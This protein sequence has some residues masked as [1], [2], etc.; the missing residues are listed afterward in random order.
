[1]FYETVKRYITKY[2]TVHDTLI[3]S[4]VL[5]GFIIII[6]IIIVVVAAAVAVTV[7]VAEIVTVVPFF[8]SVL[9]HVLHKVFN[10]FIIIIIII[11]NCILVYTRWQCA[12]VQD[13]TTQYNTIQ[14]TV[15]Q[16]GTL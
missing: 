13:R 6:I 12:T 14:H 4:C 7:V 11:I 15:C 2:S 3:G 5:V 8:K 10:I 9:E 1:M 16:E